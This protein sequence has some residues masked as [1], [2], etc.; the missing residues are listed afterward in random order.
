MA[1]LPLGA[2][3]KQVVKKKEKLLYGDQFLVWR[4]GMISI[5]Q[6]I[7]FV[8]QGWGDFNSDSHVLTVGLLKASSLTAEAE[9]PLA[10]IACTI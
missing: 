10:L 1:K 4:K 8:L 3:S 7:P 5:T 2:S 6:Y 9:A